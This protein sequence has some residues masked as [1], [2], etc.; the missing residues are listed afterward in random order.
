MPSPHTYSR[1]Q[2]ILHWA[3]AAL[4]IFQL[5][6]HEGMQ[7]AWHARLRGTEV[8]MI[9]P[10]V[11]VGVTILLLVVWRIALRLTRGTPPAPASEPGPLK[12]LASSTHW[13]FYALLFILPFSG[14]AMWLA[15][16]RPAGFV[17]NYARLALIALLFLHIAGSLAHQF[18]FKTNVLQRM[19]GR[20]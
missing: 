1:T 8:A 7:D 17:H 2:I 14:L 12:L 10:H 18:W 13:A 16:I 19:L 6:A 20:V 5:V 3:I 4:V 11:V 9:N 15:E